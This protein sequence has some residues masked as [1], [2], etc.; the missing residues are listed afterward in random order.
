MN[1]MRLPKTSVALVLVIGLWHGLTLGCKTSTERTRDA[2]SSVA[3]SADDLSK[4][5]ESK[6]AEADKLYQGKIMTVTGTVGTTSTPAAGMGN[7]AVILVDA[8]QKPIV[9]CYGF[10]T[11][12]K[13]A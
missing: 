6:E 10:A 12:Q 2:A 11:D 7:P 4:A 1:I 5:Y 3:V 9:N 8:R 13:D